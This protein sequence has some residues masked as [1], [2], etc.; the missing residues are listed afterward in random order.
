MSH[1]TGNIVTRLLT[2]DQ[3]RWSIVR[4][5]R[6][7][8]WRTH[9][10]IW[11]RVVSLISSVAMLGAAICL[12]PEPPLAQAVVVE[13]LPL[14]SAS[15]PTTFVFSWP[16][17]AALSGTKSTDRAASTLYET[18]G[19]QPFKLTPGPTGSEIAAAA[20]ASNGTP[21]FLTFAP[22][23]AGG[24]LP[25][26]DELTASGPVLRYAGAP[27]PVSELP[28]SMAFGGD[29]AVWVARPIGIERDA[30]G[31][32]SKLYPVDGYPYQIIAG[33]DNDLWFTQV[34]GNEIGRMNLA[35][36]VIA[37]YPLAGSDS[38]F[39]AGAGPYSLALGP[40]SSIYFTEQRLGRI[41]R[42][43]A[44]GE[45]REIAITP[46]T[47][48]PTGLSL[49]PQPRFITSGGEGNMWFTDPGTEAV[50]R[51]TPAGEV[52]EYPIQVAS[53]GDT[54]V[55]SVPA[56]S[57]LTPTTITAVPGGLLFSEFNAK[58]IGLI[59]PSTQSTSEQSSASVSRR[60]TKASRRRGC[61]TGSASRR[62]RRT[63]VRCTRRRH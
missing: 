23:T 2:A 55:S 11:W 63:H 20:T 38:I 39:E 47:G 10:S 18:I 50:G 16:G 32:A 48:L 17:G 26:L 42:I 14:P 60:G 40:E 6:T 27:L 53:S 12:F 46:P 34:L 52:S 30:P 44:S 33:P 35:G 51:V 13:Q 41:G 19:L 24:T 8:Q 43:S 59:E 56:P 62:G 36:E 28:T 4:Q 3:R 5:S 58:A 25:E 31:T 7:T 22:S 29:G 54:H 9:R 57:Y 49:R 1:C 37:E 15:S 61:E 45:L 21:W